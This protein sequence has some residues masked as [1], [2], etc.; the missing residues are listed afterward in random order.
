MVPPGVAK[1]VLI[2]DMKFMCH[3][4]RMESLQKFPV[5]FDVF[6]GFRVVGIFFGF[7]NKNSCQRSFLSRLRYV[8]VKK[9]SS[10]K[11]F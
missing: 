7:G 9:F 11:V 5:R 3:E 10:R 6:E 2:Y 1:P 8:I 4:L